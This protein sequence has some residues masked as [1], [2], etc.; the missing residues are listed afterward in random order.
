MRTKL[1]G[2][3]GT[4]KTTRLLDIVDRELVAEVK[5]EEV[6][7]VSFTKRAAD[8]AR[9]RACKK[10]NLREKEF[11]YFRT[12]HSLAFHHL[13]MSPIQ[14][15]GWNDYMVLCKQLG[16]T[17]T[18]RKM[19]DEWAYSGTVTKGD[20]LF[21]LENLARTTKLS[22]R[23]TWEK[24]VN[25]D[26]DFRELELVALTIKAYKESRYK[27]DF[28]DMIQKFVEH[29]SSPKFKT[30]I[31][32][33]A[34]DLSKLQW[35]MVDILEKNSKEMWVAG[36][37]DQAIYTWAGADVN[38]FIELEAQTEVLNHSYRLT[39]GVKL[40]ADKLSARMTTRL[41]KPYK[42]RN[43]ANG[44]TRLNDYVNINMK[45]GTWLLLARNI[46]ALSEYVKHCIHKGYLF[47]SKLNPD[48]N[49]ESWEAIRYWEALRKGQSLPVSCI[50]L[51]YQFMQ[52]KKRITFGAKTKLDLLP[53]HQMIDLIELVKNYGC[54]TT[55]IWEFALNK[56]TQTEVSYY[57]AAIRNGESLDAPARIRIG[58]IHS[59]KGAEAD[60]VVLECD[61][62]PKTYREYERNQDNE[63]RVWYVA[64]TRA[65]EK[66]YL[67]NPK[68]QYFYN[69]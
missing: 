61:M 19:N 51:V 48:F 9:E 57:T 8:E 68:T 3:P 60:N 16:I 26:I 18:S 54:L 17:I 10:F 62:S 12:L 25:D 21:F 69:L 13:C 59:M 36:D 32:D 30:L 24:F 23:Q 28:T 22:L 49:P 66:L 52:T 29:G 45:E 11:P 58:T 65:K 55:D 31:V 6:C 5:P 67:I 41:K 1:L 15:M 33:E 39:C 64:V 2:P 53:E 40:L 50:K 27:F 42:P 35:E 63:H 37:D 46:Y 20:R 4:G 14:V 38:H 34:Q 44:I 43:D 7:Y 47:E 56:L